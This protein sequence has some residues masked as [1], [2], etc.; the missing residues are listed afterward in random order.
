MELP[1]P[2]WGAPIV[3]RGRRLPVGAIAD[4]DRRRARQAVR[5]M[6]AEAAGAISRI[7]EAGG[8]DGG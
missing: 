1:A 6:R 3:L 8:V 7:L 5:Q 2:Q 4:R